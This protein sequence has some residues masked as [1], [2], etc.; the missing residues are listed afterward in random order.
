MGTIMG[1]ITV[2]ES[3]DGGSG[4]P[5]NTKWQ[6]LINTGGTAHDAVNTSNDKLADTMRLAI[7]TKSRVAVAF[8]DDNHAIEQ[9]RIVFNY[10]CEKVS[11][12]PC[13]PAEPSDRTLTNPPSGRPTMLDY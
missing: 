2:F 6:F 8:K 11:I 10:I 4:N 3:S 1:Y 13:A 9:V 5:A 12:Q 7:Q